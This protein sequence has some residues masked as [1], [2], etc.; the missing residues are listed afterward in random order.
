MI[1][2]FKD[3]AVACLVLANKCASN[4]SSLKQIV[5]VWISK[6]SYGGSNKHHAQ[7]D[8]LGSVRFRLHV[9]LPHSEILRVADTEELKRKLCYAPPKFCLIRIGVFATVQKSWPNCASYSLVAK[10][11]R[12]WDSSGL[13]NGS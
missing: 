1:F 12:I 9:N 10:I 11:F 8:G 13:S 4:V 3:V 2:A 5:R 6:K 7:K